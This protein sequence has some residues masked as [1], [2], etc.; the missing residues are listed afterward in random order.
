[1][2]TGLSEGDV[3]QIASMFK[4]RKFFTGETITKEGIAAAAFFVIESGETMVS[5]HGNQSG[6]RAAAVI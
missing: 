3:S 6:R 5:I 1:M 4:E 2:F